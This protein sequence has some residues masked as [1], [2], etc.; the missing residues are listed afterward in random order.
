LELRD[1]GV[2]AVGDMRD[3]YP[4]PVQARTGDL[5]DA[6]ERPVLDGAELCKIDLRPGR[7]CKPRSRG[8]GWRRGPGHHRLHELV[9]VL[10]KDPVLGPR[11]GDAPE[12][13]AQLARELSHSWTRMRFLERLLVDDGRSDGRFGAR[14]RNRRGWTPVLLARG[15]RRLLV[16]SVRL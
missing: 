13:G 5:L 11:P 14:R 8:S 7:D 3:R 12:I 4:V 1:V 15:G 16:P 2:L 9:E 10:G 6:R